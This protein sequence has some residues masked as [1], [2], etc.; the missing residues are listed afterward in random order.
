MESS[1]EKINLIVRE[2]LD[3]FRVNQENTFGWLE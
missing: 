3:R 1:Q 2:G